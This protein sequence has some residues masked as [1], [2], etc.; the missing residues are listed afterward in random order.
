MSTETKRPVTEKR[1]EK[2]AAGNNGADGVDRQNAA[3]KEFEGTTPE[4]RRELFR[5]S[6]VKRLDLGTATD[7]L[8]NRE[9]LHRQT[10]MYHLAGT[11]KEAT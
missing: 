5:R 2:P 10:S 11:R 1:K 4:L 3:P 6:S 8:E 7:R 9:G